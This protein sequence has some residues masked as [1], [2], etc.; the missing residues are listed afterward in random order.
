MRKEQVKNINGKGFI[1]ALD[2]CSS[3]KEI[4][5]L[6][7]KYMDNGTLRERLKNVRD[8]DLVNTFYAQA[9][10]VNADHGLRTSH[11]DCVTMAAD[12]YRQI[13]KRG[14]KFFKAEVNKYLTR[15]EKKEEKKQ[16]EPVVL[17][18]LGKRR[19]SSS[20]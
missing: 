19:L 8:N 4:F 20:L 14:V 6:L 11:Q 10:R 12:K 13:T 18:E 7:N 15:L 2:M 1:A 9:A 16:L 5:E 3:D 17:A